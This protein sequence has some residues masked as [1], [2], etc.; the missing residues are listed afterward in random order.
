MTAL[1]LFGGFLKGYG[2]TKLIEKD[3]KD[4]KALQDLQKRVLEIQLQNA[5]LKQKEVDLKNTLLQPVIQQFQQQQQAKSLEAPESAKNVGIPQVEDQPAFS[6]RFQGQGGLTSQMANMQ[7]ANM[8]PMMAALL[9]EFTGVDF[10]GASRMGLQQQEYKRDFLK[11]VYKERTSQTGEKSIMALPQFGTVG[12]EIPSGP[13]ETEFEEKEEGGIKY[14]RVINKTTKRAMGTWEPIAG[15]KALPAET[16]GKLGML[17]SGLG[18]MQKAK[19]I[20]I[21]EGKITADTKKRI[22]EMHTPVFKGGFP[23]SKGREAK[24]YIL[25]AMESK[26]RIES[27]AA[28]PDQEIERLALRFMPHPF[29][30]DELVLSK[31]QR[32]EEYLSGAIEKLDPNKNYSSSAVS[33]TS[34]SGDQFVLIPKT[35]KGKNLTENMAKEFLKRAGGDKTRAR[36]MARSEGYNF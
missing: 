30:S 6:S 10:L 7:M 15:K 28:V 8:D 24:S 25:N 34:E 26:I 36:E 21:P 3:R 1:N 13:A 22:L 14:R 5:K 18:D 32:M 11:P 33:F 19:A 4:K 16:A 31:L 9:K 29:D 12:M 17:E 2:Q 20:L 23:F 27:G 35:K